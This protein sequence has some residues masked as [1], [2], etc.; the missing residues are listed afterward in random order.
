MAEALDALDQAQAALVE[1]LD[2][3]FLGQTIP[4]EIWRARNQLDL[5]YRS[6]QATLV[7]VTRDGPAE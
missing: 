6:L 7:A 1:T 3:H 4:G 5:A 2:R